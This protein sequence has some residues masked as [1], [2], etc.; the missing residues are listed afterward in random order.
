MVDYLGESNNRSDT[1]IFLDRYRPDAS[2]AAYGFQVVVING[3]DDQQTPNTPAQNTAGKDLE[4][5][6]DIQTILAFDYP[7]PAVAFTTGG[8]PPFQPDTVSIRNY[9]QDS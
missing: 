5:N 2:S 7:T 3:G 6:L 8:Q 1:K 9:E 4:G